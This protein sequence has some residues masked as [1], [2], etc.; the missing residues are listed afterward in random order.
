MKC[1]GIDCLLIH[2]LK[3]VSPIQVFPIY[4]WPVQHCRC[5]TPGRVG[6]ILGY[7]GHPL[8][9]QPQSLLYNEQK[10]MFLCGEQL[11]SNVGTSCSAL[12]GASSS[13]SVWG[14][15]EEPISSPE[16]LKLPPLKFL[17]RDL[18]FHKTYKCLILLETQRLT[19]SS[20]GYIRSSHSP[21]IICLCPNVVW[22]PTT[23]EFLKS[24]FPD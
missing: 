12:E 8:T 21:S 16:H 9:F 5:V 3:K 15:I 18:I 4:L 10:E 14:D 1:A 17:I 13:P 24:K 2:P 23:A 7:L 6:V 22:A 19:C 11:R 20:Q